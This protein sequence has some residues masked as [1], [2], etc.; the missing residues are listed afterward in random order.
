MIT[1]FV[2]LQRFTCRWRL[3]R[4]NS[5]IHAHACIFSVKRWLNQA[6]CQSKFRSKNWTNLSKAGLHLA[7]FSGEL[8]Q[9]KAPVKLLIILHNYSNV[10]K[11]NPIQTFSVW[12]NGRIVTSQEGVSWRR[13]KEATRII[14]KSCQII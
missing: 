13:P 4:L 10:L 7:A 1:L 6:R 12:Q 2:L 8:Y 11:I 3:I 9:I 14:Y 5:W